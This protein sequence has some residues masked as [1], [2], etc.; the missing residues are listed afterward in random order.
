M[1]AEGSASTPPLLPRGLWAP[2]ATPLDDALEPDSFLLAAHARDL[3]ARG[4]DG[5]LLFGTTGEA[6][7]FA[8]SQRDDALAR[9]L[10]E[11]LDPSRVAVGTGASSLRDVVAL[12]G[13]ATRRGVAGC[14]IVPPF[15]F[16]EP[17]VE[18][19][20][21]FYARAIDQARPEPGSV[22]LYHFPRLSRVP[23]TAELVAR[24]AETHP[25]AVGGLKDSSGDVESARGFVELGLDVFCG[26]EQMLAPLAEAGLA[27]CIT[28][29][30]NVGPEP[31]AAL[32]AAL[33]ARDSRAGEIEAACLELRAAVEA[34]GM[35]PAIKAIVAERTRRAAW[36]R[37]LPPLMPTDAPPLPDLSD[38]AGYIERR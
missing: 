18:G 22:W 11:G 3:L 16:E 2:L 36:T 27:G 5:V 25:G 1:G 24:L 32:V 9:L 34:R 35:I 21:A 12:T 37:V 7:S 30:A 29:T 28:A 4:C 38:L 19:L 23:I 10:D 26:H 33:R 6:P 31:I 8:R 15:Y 20:H 13:A 14:L 17:S